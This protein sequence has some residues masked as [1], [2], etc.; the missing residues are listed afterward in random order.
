VR[1][2][3]VHAWTRRLRG[4]RRALPDEPLVSTR[5][6]RRSM[7]QLVEHDVHGRPPVRMRGR[8]EIPASIV[9]GWSCATGAGRRHLAHPGAVG[10]V[11]PVGK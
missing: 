4:G 2:G 8:V 6:G 10:G 3:P 1:A 7:A 9:V 11:A 5:F